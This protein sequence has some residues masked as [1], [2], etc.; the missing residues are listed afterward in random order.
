MYVHARSARASEGRK[1]K[2]NVDD[3]R[4]HPSAGPSLGRVHGTDPPASF[5][6]AGRPL[7]ANGSTFF[8]PSPSRARAGRIAS[9]EV[10]LGMACR[11]GPPRTIEIQDQGR[12]IPT[13]CMNRCGRIPMQHRPEPWPRGVP[14]GKGGEGGDRIKDR[15]SASR[16]RP[17]CSRSPSTASSGPSSPRPGT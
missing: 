1:K 17:P 11:H 2:K 9:F 3:R 4:L 13:T 14:T 10:R 15:A 12:R 8:V 7:D 16:W 5:S 6:I